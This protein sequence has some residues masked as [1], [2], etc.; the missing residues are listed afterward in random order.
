MFDGSATRLSGAL[1]AFFT[2]PSSP[3]Y[4]LTRGVHTTPGATALTRMLSGPNSTAADLTSAIRPALAAP[5]AAWRGADVRPDT[6]ATN[7]IVPPPFSLR[8]GAAYCI[9]IHA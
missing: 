8:S 2:L 9:A 3:R 4:A 6:D 1:A 5:Y 7:V